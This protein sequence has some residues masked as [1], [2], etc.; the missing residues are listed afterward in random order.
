MLFRSQDIL[1]CFS[2]GLSEV[3][4]AAGDMFDAH[5][6]LRVVEGHRT[7]SAEAICGAL[8]EEAAKFAGHPLRDD[9]SILVLKFP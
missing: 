8:Q 3:E 6:I 7:S 4:N 5:R 2:D 1:V 9:L